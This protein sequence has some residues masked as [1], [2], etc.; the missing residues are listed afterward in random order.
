MKTLDDVLPKTT[1]KPMCLQDDI[2]EGLDH[3]ACVFHEMCEFI[4]TCPLDG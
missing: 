1:E 2:P 3:E 4:E